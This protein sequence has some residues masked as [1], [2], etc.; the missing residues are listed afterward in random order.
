MR[1]S[2]TAK[3]PTGIFRRSQYL[4]STSVVATVEDQRRVFYTK[5]NR[6]ND[7]MGK[8]CL[9]WESKSFED[10]FHT[11][12]AKEYELQKAIVDSVLIS[13]FNT[14]DKL[15]VQLHTMAPGCSD[16]VRSLL[17]KGRG[18]FIGQCFFHKKNGYRGVIFKPDARCRMDESWVQMMGVRCL[19]RGPDQPFYHCLVDVRDRPGAQTTYVAEDNVALSTDAFTIQHPLI[20]SLFTEVPELKCYVGT[21]SLDFI[22]SEYDD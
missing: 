6:S 2:L 11:L 19:E 12:K 21:D 1:L 4:S 5:C 13:N 8:L 17:E 3:H 22:L 18:K 20:H 14:A 16:E 7:S 10:A 15:K 9:E